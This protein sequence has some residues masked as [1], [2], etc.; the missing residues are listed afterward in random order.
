MKKI[1]S[2][3]LLIVAS[4]GLAFNAYAGQRIS[5]SEVPQ[6]IQSFVQ[7][8]FGKNISIVKASRD[9]KAGGYEYDI[10]LSNG[11]EI[12]YG[13][14]GEWLEVDANGTREDIPRNIVGEE[15]SQQ[16]QVKYPGR[17]VRK[18][19][20]ESQGFEIVLDN[21]QHLMAS[22]NGATLTEIIDD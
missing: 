12:D 13:V 2:L 22:P 4:L 5:P 3:V 7:D 20:R 15:I 16:I 8:N 9:A 14:N 21:G 6:P 10:K 19:E 18:I 11:V 1:A 17:H